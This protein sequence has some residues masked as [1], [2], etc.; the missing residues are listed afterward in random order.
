MTWQ[1]QAIDLWGVLHWKSTLANMLGVNKSTIRR[2]ATGQH[3]MKPD[4]VDKINA[5]Y[6]IWKSVH[7]K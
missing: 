3:K 7:S 2:W 5:T 4:V 1:E 6:E